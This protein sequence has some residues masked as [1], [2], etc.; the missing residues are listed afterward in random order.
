MRE[1]SSSAARGEA[2]PAPAVPSWDVDLPVG[3]VAAFLVDAF[4]DAFYRHTPSLQ[5]PAGRAEVDVAS[6]TA[7][8]GAALLT[9][10][11]VSGEAS[12]AAGPAVRRGEVLSEQCP[13][14]RLV[15]RVL[16]LLSGVAR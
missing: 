14:N 12:A 4:V 15:V 10:A 2:A 7:E 16:E 5:A 9:L 3:L 8:S 13:R 11:V 6:F 1:A